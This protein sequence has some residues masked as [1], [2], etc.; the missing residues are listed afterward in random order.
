[1]RWYLILLT[2]LSFI[3]SCG[4]GGGEAGCNDLGNSCVYVSLEPQTIDAD[5]FLKQDTNNDGICDTGTLQPFLINVN[6]NVQPINQNAPTSPV[7]LRDYTL[8]FVPA[9]LNTPALQEKQKTISTIVYPNSPKIISI[10]I[11]NQNDAQ[12]LYLNGAF[13]NLF[14]YQVIIDFHFVELISG[15]DATLRKYIYIKVSDFVDQ[16]RVQ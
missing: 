4:G 2:I 3:L 14:E 8:K 5:I 16:C 1:M 15:G 10:E 7:E 11:L 6:I 9:N 13:A 12:Y